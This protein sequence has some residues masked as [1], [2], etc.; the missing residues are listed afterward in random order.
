MGRHE[1]QSAGQCL[2]IPRLDAS[3]VST[4]LPGNTGDLRRT[5]SSSGTSFSITSRAARIERVALVSD[6]TL[7]S[8]E[9]EAELRCARLQPIEVL[10]PPC[11][12][13]PPSTCRQDSRRQSATAAMTA[14]RGRPGRSRAVRARPPAAP[15]P[16]TA[17]RSHQTAGHCSRCT[18]QTHME[19][20]QASIVRRP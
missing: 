13:R 14:A 11:L 16:V 8:V 3:T 6:L 18:K 17:A 4:P 5:R 19:A 7:G 9:C 12:P 2:K 15:P 20:A 1:W 10:C